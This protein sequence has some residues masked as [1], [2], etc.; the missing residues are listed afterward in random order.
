ML[1]VFQYSQHIL[2]LLVPGFEVIVDRD[3][4][5]AKCSTLNTAL[6]NFC[7]KGS[8]VKASENRRSM[9]EFTHRHE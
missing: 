8:T 3:I 5:E 1:S 4:K 7:H 6:G 2:L 9:T